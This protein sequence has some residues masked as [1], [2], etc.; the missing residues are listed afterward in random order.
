MQCWRNETG[1]R[2]PDE[3]DLVQSARVAIYLS[4][5]EKD[6][7]ISE[8]TLVLTSHRIK[9]VNVMLSLWLED[10]LGWEG[11]T[12]FLT[13]SPKIHLTVQEHDN[14]DVVSLPPW[15]CPACEDDNEGGLLRCA[16]CG[17]LNPVK[18]PATFK[19]KA[20]HQVRLSF[21]SSGYKSFCEHL[22]RALDKRAWIQTAKP[23]TSY[24][25]GVSGLLRKAAADQQLST[26]SHSQAFEDLDA[27]VRQ[28]G[29]MAKLA[30]SITQKLAKRGEILGEAED[31]EFR[32]LI[33]DLGIVGD[34]SGSS[35]SREGSVWLSELA[36]QLSAFTSK[37]VVLRS[38]Q[39]ATLSDVYCYF[40]RARGTSLVSPSDLAKAAKL[41]GVL[42]LPVRLR[43]L[44]SGLAVLHDVSFND[45]RLKDRILSM[46]DSTGHVTASDLA[47]SESLSSQLAAELLATLDA[48]GALCHDATPSGLHYHPNI[49]LDLSLDIATLAIK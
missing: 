5:S 11:K 49:F 47:R 30:E 25:P 29:E 7:S 32:A 3:H 16:I 44:S 40:N 24:A 42:G 35:S 6:P 1:D 15:K 34:N 23:P 12:G 37:L 19:N 22:S 8:Q 33:S 2:L 10:V 41:M 36:R 26:K 48:A 39:M 20:T 9:I 14:K 27:L 4:P 28:A 18:P 46:M 38:V 31:R 43:I 21:R 17:T 45:D 13:S